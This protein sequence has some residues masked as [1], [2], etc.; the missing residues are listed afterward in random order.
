MSMKCCLCS[1][2]ILLTNC[3]EKRRLKENVN[4]N[5]VRHLTFRMIRTRDNV[6]KIE[7]LKMIKL[8]VLNNNLWQKGDLLL[9]I[10]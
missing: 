3:S 9:Y 10:S 7:E 5:K 6:G 1:R 2:S 8:Y 4:T